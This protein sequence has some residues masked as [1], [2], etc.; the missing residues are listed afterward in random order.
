MAAG[1]RNIIIEKKATFNKTDAVYSGKPSKLNPTPADIALDITNAVL[2]PVN[3]TGATIS[4]KLKRNINDTTPVI[5]FTTAIVDA[6][7]GK[8]SF[9]LTA[10]QTASLSIDTGVYDV[11]IT[12]ASGQV[13]K[14]VE[15]NVRVDRTAS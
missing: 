8:Y 2:V 15:G 5:G 12:L 1:K 4:A 10:A 11:L 3:L 7:N 9:S 13:I 14:V 6:A